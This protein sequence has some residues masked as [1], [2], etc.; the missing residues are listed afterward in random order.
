VLTRAGHALVVAALALLTLGLG[1]ANPLLVGASSLPVV[2]LALG[3]ADPAAS[4][5]RARLEVP[6]RVRAGDLVTVRAHVTAGDD[7]GPAA[8]RV[9]LPDSFDVV[10]GADARLVDLDPGETTTVAVTARA[11][12]R[13]RVDVGPVQAAPLHAAG[14]RAAETRTLADAERIDVD[15]A[16]A[17]LSRLREIRGTATTLAPEGDDARLGLRTTDF[18][19]LREYRPGDPPRNVNWKATARLGPAADAPLV[20]E[21]EVEG[22]KAVWFFLDAGRHMAVG[23][24]V[25]NGF[26]QAVAA[27][28]GLALA[29]LD[30]GYQVGL[31]TYNGGADEPL[32][33]DAGEGQARRV[34]D[35]LA[36]L[37]PGEADEGPVGAVE[38]CRSWLAQ[39]SPMVVFVTRTE[40]DT[41]RLEGAIR[42]IR[43]LD[44]DRRPIV[45]VEPQPF[46]L[47][48]GDETE[49]AT[50]RLLEHLARPRHERLRALGAI[51]LPWNP[52]REPLERLLFRGVPPRA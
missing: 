51:V 26:E 21:Y 23:T 14:L 12:K 4:F 15:P 25:E 8:V 50:A 35:R 18:R 30:Q 44:S 43:G 46:H 49:R 42:R 5:A 39:V 2:A 1:T 31:Q 20:N 27:A 13:G 41:A 28:G 52:E 6:D 33:P 24:T 38:R 40:T 10:D 16:L 47:V 37:A 7:G 32:Y 3:L 36:D 19:E 29:Y 11:P 17:S 45:V 9:D 48:P 34:Q 22:R